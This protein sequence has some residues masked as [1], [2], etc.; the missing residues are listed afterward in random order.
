MWDLSGL[1]PGSEQKLDTPVPEAG[2]E[3]ALGGDLDL[4]RDPDT[5]SRLKTV[6]T[7]VAE[8]ALGDP[9]QQVGLA[10]TPP[11]K[12]APGQILTVTDQP[13]LA[14]CGTS[15]MLQTDLDP[16]RDPAHLFKNEQQHPPPQQLNVGLSL[17]KEE[18]PVDG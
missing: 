10:P 5:C 16:N 2:E 1:K 7:P 14:G 13:L 11:L 4:N 15:L 6:S 12:P 9:G 17:K 8:A 3:P 18:Q